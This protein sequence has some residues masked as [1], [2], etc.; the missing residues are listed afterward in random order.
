MSN[1]ESALVSSSWLSERPGDPNIRIIEVSAAQEDS[2]Y[3]A[4]HLPGAVWWHWKNALWLA[5][6][7]EFATPEEMGNRL[8]VIGVSPQ[9]TVVLYGDPVSICH[10]C[11]LGS[12]HVR[13][14]GC[15]DVGWGSGTLD[16]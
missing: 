5:T 6:D 11:V 2:N 3:R 14:S 9:T 4:G 15:E 12:D 1:R 16:E 10:L 8:G 7:R 13:A